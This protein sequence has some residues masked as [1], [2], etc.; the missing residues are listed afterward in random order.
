VFIPTPS[1]TRIGAPTKKSSKF[2]SN[3]KLSNKLLTKKEKIKKNYDRSC[4][5]A[6]KEA[7]GH[8]GIILHRRLSEEQSLK[9]H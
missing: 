5:N 8:S 9:N 2:S 6:V 1:T 7:A 4:I 3:W